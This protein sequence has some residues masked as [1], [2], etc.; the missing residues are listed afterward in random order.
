MVRRRRSAAVLVAALVISCL[1]LAGLPLPAKAAAEEKV[2]CIWEDG[3]RTEPYAAAYDA[4][5][6]IRDDGTIGLVRDGKHGYV[7]TGQAFA[8]VCDVLRFGTLAELCSLDMGGLDKLERAAIMQAFGNQI[9]YAGGAFAIVGDTVA[10]M[11]LTQA[12]CVR[13]LDGTLPRDYLAET[14][15]S[16]LCIMGPS[17]AITADRLVGSGIARVTAV[18]PYAAEQD[19]LYLDTPGGRRLIAALPCAVSLTVGDCDFLDAGA[20]SP[21]EALVS[22]TLP[23]LGGAKGGPEEDGTLLRLFETKNG[24]PMPAMLASVTVTGGEIADDAFYGFEL[25]QVTL[26]GAER[27]SPLAFVGANVGIIH[28][29]CDALRLSGPY[30]TERAPCGC[31][32]YT[33]EDP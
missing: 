16:A 27:V 9:Y 6:G 5:D 11:E 29:P 26:C 33:K 20:L 1:V 4:L 17:A 10:P 12:D 23:F 25:A 3:A 21:C 8:E 30:R 7:K 32:V 14:G 28:A 19:A 22:L 31:T 18:P 15:A 24:A 13:L 2:L